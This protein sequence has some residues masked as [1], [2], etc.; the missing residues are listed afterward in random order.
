M[1]ERKPE[2]PYEG[3]VRESV[4]ALPS[5]SPAPSG[6][7]PS[8]RSIGDP[9]VES[10]AVSIDGLE[11]GALIERQEPSS[12]IDFSVSERIV[13]P[14]PGPLAN[15]EAVRQLELSPE[16]P[17]KSGGVVYSVHVYTPHAKTSGFPENSYA[18]TSIDA[19]TRIIEN[20]TPAQ[21]GLA[22]VVVD[23]LRLA[24]SVD[25]ELIEKNLGSYQKNLAAGLAKRK[26]SGHPPP[27]SWFEENHEP[28]SADRFETLI[29]PPVEPDWTCSACKLVNPP[30][31]QDCARCAIG[32]H[33]C[34]GWGGGCTNTLKW[35]DDRGLCADCE[36]AKL[37][38]ELAQRKPV[39]PGGLQ[40][41]TKTESSTED[42]LKQREDAYQLLWENYQREQSLCTTMAKQ[43]YELQQSLTTAR[44]DVDSARRERDEVK[45]KLGKTVKQTWDLGTEL[46]ELQY[47]RLQARGV[48][49]AWREVSE[50]GKY[51]VTWSIERK[52][53]KNG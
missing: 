33:R 26:E 44:L 47:E 38:A 4:D 25:Q 2:S 49:D 22:Q 43:A 3:P 15:P 50:D 53:E 34:P 13:L 35:G 7:E 10:S 28:L 14:S 27:K 48:L 36:R 45:E 8:D 41:I 6:E 12:N 9:A 20:A 5:P 16:P 40:G 11:Q 23:I 19:I 52:K 29:L 21:R 24:P 32:R 51:P 17:P 46:E 30:T 39:S 37:R 1:S 18:E 42:L 31:R